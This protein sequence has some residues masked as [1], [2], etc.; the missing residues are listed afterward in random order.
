MGSEGAG[1]VRVGLDT[2]VV[3]RLL[4]GEPQLQAQAAWQ[5]VVEIRAAGGEAVVSDLVVSE[6]YFALQD[7]YAVPKREALRQ[8]RE[9]FESGDLVPAG[10]ATRVLATPRLA[11]AKPG[12][13]DRM[14]HAGYV[15]NLDQMLS[16]EK[17][18][19]KLLR[20]RVLEG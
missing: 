15:S 18:A 20:T 19:R 10:C 11:A 2:S 16:F 5:A 3:L 13:V 4:I 8:L 9:L 7:H 6:T 12:F 14:I 1:L 17:A